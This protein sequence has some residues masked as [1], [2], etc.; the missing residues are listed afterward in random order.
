MTIRVCNKHYHKQT[1][2]DVEI[3]RPS[4]F[5]NPWS[6]LDSSFEG[7]K[8]TKTR[9]EAVDNY[10]QYFIE[11]YK[12]DVKFRDIVDEIIKL[13]L[14][15]QDINL[16]CWCSPAQ[17]HGDVIKQFIEFKAKQNKFLD[18]NQL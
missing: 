9:K 3:C 5:G 10:I 11:K 16:T 12:K 1:D 6:H 14:Q 7:A 15:G 17:C 4:I 18:S 8:K 13:H 2:N